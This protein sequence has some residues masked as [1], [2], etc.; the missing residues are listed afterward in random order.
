MAQVVENWSDVRGRVVETSPSTARPEFV[1]VV[2]AADEVHAVDDWPDLLGDVA[3]QQIDV[4][5]PRDSVGDDLEPG[6][7]IACRVRR[8]R[9]GLFAHPDH[10]EVDPGDDGPTVS[11]A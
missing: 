4:L 8:A 6:A 2:I 1:E 9:S 10:V 7:A 11:S 5:V 3:G